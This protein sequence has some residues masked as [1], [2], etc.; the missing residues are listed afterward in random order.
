M[1]TTSIPGFTDRRDIELSNAYAEITRLREENARLKASSAAVSTE[2][3]TVEPVA[4]TSGE[5][6]GHLFDSVEDSTQL[7]ISMTAPQREAL[8]RS[9][10]VLEINSNGAQ[11]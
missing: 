4:K 1:P 2:V 10:K 9:I 3:A 7:L 11:Q 5:R 8:T 6:I